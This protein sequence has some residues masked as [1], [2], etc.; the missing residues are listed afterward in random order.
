MFESGKRW[1]A[2]P[3]SV[4]RSLAAELS[5][6]SNS[7]SK[8]IVL[9]VPVHCNTFLEM[10]GSR[11]KNAIGVKPPKAKLWLL[12]RPMEPIGPMW[13]IDNGFHIQD[14]AFSRAG[15]RPFHFKI[16]QTIK[17]PKLASPFRAFFERQGGSRSWRHLVSTLFCLSLKKKNKEKQF[18]YLQHSRI[19]RPFGSV[20]IWIFPTQKIRSTCIVICSRQP[21]NWNSSKILRLKFQLIKKSSVSIVNELRC[22]LDKFI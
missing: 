3:T 1:R 13:E 11:A 16:S 14:V 15:C 8:A 18:G 22:H 9:R 21:I 20:R 7:H 10:N 2:H 6:Q 19:Q 5:V 17:A 12:P 4:F